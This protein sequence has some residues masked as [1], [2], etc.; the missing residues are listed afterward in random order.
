MLMCGGAVQLK[1]WSAGWATA[2][3]LTF[4]TIGAVEAQ[5]VPPVS[6]D[7]AGKGAADGTV[8]IYSSQTTQFL[9][10]LVGN[11]K[12]A[13]PD[14]KMQYLKD[15]SSGIAERLLSEEAA[16]VHTAD[17]YIAWWDTVS[18]VIDAGDTVSYTPEQASAYDAS[19]SDPKGNWHIV[20][21]NPLLI[22]YNTQSVAEADVP[23][24]W[25]D[26]LDPKWSDKIG[27]YDP[28]IGGGAYAYYYGMW[29]LYGDDYFTRLAANK[30]FV[31]GASAALASAVG[32]G[33]LSL[34]SIGY[35]GWS[36]LLGEAPIALIMPS[37]GVPMMDMMVSIVK[38][39]PHANAAKLFVSW[40]MSE[41]GQK[42]IP[43]NESAIYA[44][45][46]SIAPPAGVP[47]LSEIKRVPIDYAEY[48]SQADAITK[49]ASEAFGLST[50]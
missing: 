25:Q 11:F 15:S 43:N 2:L 3:V 44:A 8:V 9:D 34:A 24:T 12:A 5:T 37:D 13:Y 48:I 32:S 35:T 4:G 14:V 18:R 27:T 42:A 49:K 38:D 30:P 29:K 19:L 26:L 36:S 23:K 39:A 50:D 1:R 46:P 6:S 22:G 16:G 41:A 40:L 28:R 45:L 21:F 47:P 33:Q 10:G 20:G 31:Q 17:V 7:L